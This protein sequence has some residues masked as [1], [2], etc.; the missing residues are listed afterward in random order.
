[1]YYTSLLTL[2]TNIFYSGMLASHDVNN[3]TLRHDVM[4]STQANT[5][6]NVCSWHRTLQC[7]TTILYYS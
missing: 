4:C 6:L 1:M 2:P 5:A 3:G 7:V